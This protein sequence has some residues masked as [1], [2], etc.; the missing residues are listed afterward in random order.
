MEQLTRRRV[1]RHVAL[2]GVRQVVRHHCVIVPRHDAVAGEGT[3]A[4]VVRQRRD[5]CRGFESQ[6]PT[7][8]F[9]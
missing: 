2:C 9:P 8:D 6:R 7:E 5:T 1:V 4:T 3:V